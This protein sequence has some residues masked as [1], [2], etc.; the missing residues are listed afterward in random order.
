MFICLYMTMY[1][2]YIQLHRDVPFNLYAHTHTYIHIYIH[3]INITNAHVASK[4]VGQ[5]SG[6]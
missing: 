2:T 3:D 1:S 4:D 5:I 6:P